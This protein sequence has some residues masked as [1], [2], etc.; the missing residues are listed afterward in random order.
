MEIA[1]RIKGENHAAALKWAEEATYADHV[2]QVIDTERDIVNYNYWRLR[3]ALEP[4]DDTLD[5]RK[6]FY[7]GDREFNEAH[8][9]RAEAA[10]V[11]GLQSWR[12]V[13]DKHPALL[14]DQN[15]TDQLF[16]SIVRYRSLLH[17]LQ[18]PFPDPFVLQDVLDADMTFHGPRMP[19]IGGTQKAATEESKPAAATEGGTPEAA[20]ATPAETAPPAPAE[21]TPPAEPAGDQPPTKA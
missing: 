21:S 4:E 18:Q 16:D 1:D 15:L 7:D 14:K 2:S 9:E 12:K 5:A 11:A 8:L 20:P 13:L 3:C 19:A 6:Q 17:Q 10:Y